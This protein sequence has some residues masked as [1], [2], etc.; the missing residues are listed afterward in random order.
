MKAA[1]RRDGKKSS[2]VIG[3]PALG[4]GVSSG[5][6]ISIRWRLLAFAAANDLVDEAAIPVQ[7]IEV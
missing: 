3:R 7:V 6:S 2:L 4:S 5:R 1:L